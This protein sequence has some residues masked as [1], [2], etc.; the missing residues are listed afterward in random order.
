MKIN[1]LPVEIRFNLEVTLSE[2][3]V[4]KL[5]LQNLEA[6][7]IEH[8]SGPDLVPGGVLRR[9]AEELKGEISKMAKEVYDV[10]LSAL[11]ERSTNNYN[12]RKKGG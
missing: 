2:L 8:L 12:Q 1:R 9:D 5:A 11:C 7:Y 6:Q 4:I 10:H 3:G